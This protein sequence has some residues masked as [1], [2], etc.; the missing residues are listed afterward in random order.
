MELV[1]ETREGVPLLHARGAG[2][3][4][5]F[6]S[7]GG[8]V[9]DGT[10]ASLNLGFATPDDPASVAENRR[11]ALVAAGADPARTFALRQRHGTTVVEAGALPPGSYLD[12][13]F[14]WPE[15]DALVTSRP[16]SALVAHG[17]DCLTVALVAA[18]GAR[19]SAVHAGWRGLVAGVL[20]AAAGAVGPGFAAAV[21]PGAGACC[22]EVGEEVAAPIRA[23]FGEDAVAAGHADL[24]LCARRALESAGAA[25][26][27]V[28]NLCTICDAEH[29]H[30]HRRDGALSGRQAVIVTIGEG[31]A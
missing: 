29:F 23:R 10:F 26:V 2:A 27:A 5:A 18:G 4:I 21:G 1:W 7:R 19:V 6:T 16:G 30:S 9:S 25:E 8:G 3:R 20:E 28:A 14:A 22:Y 12:A 11:R 13:S 31:Y 17:A 24:A 15:A